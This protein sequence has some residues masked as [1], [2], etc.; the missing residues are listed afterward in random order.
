MIL[1]ELKPETGREIS[2][3][4]G[5]ESKR[6]QS[7]GRERQ[8]AQGSLSRMLELC[9]NVVKLIS[10]RNGLLRGGKSNQRA[11]IFLEEQGRLIYFLYTSLARRVIV[12]TSL[13]EKKHNR[14]LPQCTLQVDQ[15]TN[16]FAVRGSRQIS[17]NETFQKQSKAIRQSLT[18]RARSC[19]YGAF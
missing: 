16:Y 8:P 3:R 6:F 14:K 5:S 17:E 19:R 1:F 2:Q 18:K 9:N 15:S 7:E 12:K 4:T 11:G 10:P 13:T